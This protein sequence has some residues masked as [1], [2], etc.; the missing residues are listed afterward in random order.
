MKPRLDPRL[1]A[2]VDVG[3]HGPA[4]T[5][6][7]VAAALDGGVTL[8]QVR[9]KQA[10]ARILAEA[11]QALRAL[12]RARGVPLLVNDRPDVAAAVGADGVHVGQSDL[13]ATVIHRLWP[14]LLLGVSVHDEAERRDAL[15]AGADYLAA[16][17]LYAT[18]TKADATP[19][20]HDL[21]E[22]LARAGG[23]PLVGIGGITPERATEVA[24]L[25]AAGVA[26]ISGLWGATDPAAAARAYRR[27]FP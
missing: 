1:Y 23:A 25:G 22:R 9:G 14:G 4:V 3:P 18:G 26:V 2:I 7:A 6:E 12:T 13:P 19:L 20:A 21:F 8:L 5:P 24:R 15:A 10:P 16:G 11:A 27:A 17:S